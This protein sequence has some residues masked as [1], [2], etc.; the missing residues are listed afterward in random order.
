MIRIKICGLTREEDIAVV[1]NLRP[2]YIGFVFAEHSKR[3]VTPEQAQKF[4]QNISPSIQTV[5]VFVDTDI[6]TILSICKQDIIDV[7]QL[8]GKEDENYINK[9]RC[10]TDKPII[11]AYQITTLGDIK[12]AN[13]SVADYVLLDHGAGGT[14]ESFDWSLLSDVSRPFF[15]AGGL[16]P[17]NVA[18]AIEQGF[19]TTY[20]YGVDTSSGVET[21]GFKDK[22]KIEQ[23]IKTVRKVGE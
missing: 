12:K 9:L 22:I 15:L 19:S 10:H 13:D 3:A 16:H 6:E 8:H 2:D 11:K 23:F 21:N 17:G 4:R 14:G 7:I 1:N 18:G 20:L 5:G